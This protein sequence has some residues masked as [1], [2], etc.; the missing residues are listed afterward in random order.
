MLH[1]CSDF[2]VV[3]IQSFFLNFISCC[4]IS[5]HICSQHF[6]LSS[7]FAA[8]CSSDAS[9]TNSVRSQDDE[10]KPATSGIVKD[11][12]N[13]NP[14]A[15]ELFVNDDALIDVRIDGKIGVRAS[16]VIQTRANAESY[17]DSN[18]NDL[19]FNFISTQSESLSPNSY[20]RSHDPIAPV[21]DLIAPRISTKCT[22]VKG[23]M[24][25]YTYESDSYEN[26]EVRTIDAIKEDMEDSA[27]VKEN[28]LN[29]VVLGV[30]FLGSNITDAVASKDSISSSPGFVTSIIGSPSSATTGSGTLDMFTFPV[31]ILIALGAILL[32]LIA[33]FVG[34]SK[35]AN[36]RR[37]RRDESFYGN[38]SSSS[39]K[40]LN[41][42]DIFGNYSED[43]YD[44]ITPTTIRYCR[45]V[46]PDFSP[47]S[48]LR[49]LQDIS[50]TLSRTFSGFSDRAQTHGIS[51]DESVFETYE[52]TIKGDGGVRIQ[53]VKSYVDEDYEDCY[54]VG[55]IH[56]PPPPPPP[57][58]TQRR[59]VL[60]SPGRI[61]FAS[62][63]NDE[64]EIETDGLS[65]RDSLRASTTPT[66]VKTP[67]RLPNP[68]KLLTSRRS[69]H[70]IHKFRNRH[71]D[72]FDDDAFDDDDDDFSATTGIEVSLR[73][74]V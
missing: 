54:S 38:E 34:T 7:L 39:N 65:S 2:A 31:M 64:I 18:S 12:S 8:T 36:R 66:Q 60:P 14:T 48:Y 72:S 28:L 20:T 37:K 42:K 45:E 3:Y 50:N 63:S 26:L 6:P 41:S 47:S 9:A 73:P 74:A 71:D 10:T 25:L 55:T 32:V 30:K 52:A 22:V 1:C 5:N 57:L 69:K 19:A 40:E 67:R 21:Q 62:M 61:L 44:A 27:F 49:S 29:D 43:E 53:N 23:Y 17:S 56:A 58:P 11:E 16:P 59:T 13:S 4:I 15:S 35:T 70:P 24:T 68:T 46:E 33:L 51:G